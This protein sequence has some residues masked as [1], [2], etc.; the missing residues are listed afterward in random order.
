MAALQV[1]LTILGSV[2]GSGA[3]FGFIQFLIQRKDK[4]AEDEKNDKFDRLINCVKL[5]NQEIRNDETLGEGFCIGHSY[6]CKLQHDTISDTKLHNIVEFELIPLLK[7]YW[8][9]EPDNIRN[10]SENLRRAV[11]D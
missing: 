1:V 9:D 3:V 7:E 10:W 2:I 5:L 6:F 4:K 8:Y 11:S